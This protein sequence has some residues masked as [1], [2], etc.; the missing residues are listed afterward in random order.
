[1]SY[2]TDQSF[3]TI[4]NS[5]VIDLFE[6]G[7]DEF[8]HELS[9]NLCNGRMLG[10]YNELYFKVLSPFNFEEKPCKLMVHLFRP[11]TARLR[12]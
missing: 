4:E 9:I 12:P 2:Q 5:K 11:N 6:Y 3:K 8:T 10:P 7:Y 1:M